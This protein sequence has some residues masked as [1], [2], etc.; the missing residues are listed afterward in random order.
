MS[1]WVIPPPG[2]PLKSDEDLRRER[3]AKIAELGRRGLL[4]SERLRAAMLT[5][6]VQE[7]G[8]RL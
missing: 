8:V 1:G 5:V 7:Y 4:C 6:A 3:E 2:R